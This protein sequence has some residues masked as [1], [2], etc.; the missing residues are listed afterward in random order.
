MMNWKLVYQWYFKK[1]SIQTR[2]G[3]MKTERIRQYV[4]HFCKILGITS[5]RKRKKKKRFKLQKWQQRRERPEGPWQGEESICC[6]QELKYM[7]S[8]V[9]NLLLIFYELNRAFYSQNKSQW[10]VELFEQQRSLKLSSASPL[11]SQ[12]A[13]RGTGLTAACTRTRDVHKD[14]S[15]TH[16]LCVNQIFLPSK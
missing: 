12:K 3:S 15:I 9:L 7:C 11:S 1:N 14:R 13:G 2:W 5:T 8:K 16:A 4:S 10:P 6:W